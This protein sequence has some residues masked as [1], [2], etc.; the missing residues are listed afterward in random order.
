[1]PAA[2]VLLGDRAQAFSFGVPA[3]IQR[4][5]NALSRQDSSVVAHA[6]PDG[7]ARDGAPAR[8]RAPA[9]VDRH[10]PAV[11]EV[12]PEGQ[13]RAPVLRARRQGDGPGLADAVQHGLRLARRGRSRT[14][15]LLRKFDR[16][17]AGLVRDP[18]I[19]S[20]VGPGALADTSQQLNAL[21]AGPA[22]LGQ[23][24]QGRQ[25]AARHPGERARPGGRRRRPA[26]F[27]AEHRC[28]RPRGTAREPARARST[29]GS[30]RRAPAR[31][32][33]RRTSTRRS[34]LRASC[35]TARRRRSRAPRRSRATSARRP[36]PAR[37]GPRSSARWP[38]NVNTSSE[39]IKGAVGTASALNAQLAEATAAIAKLPDGPEKT[40]CRRRD[41]V[42]QLG[43]ERP[44]VLAE[45]DQQHAQR[46][47]RRGL[48]GLHAD[49]PALDRPRPALRGLERAGGGHR[50][51]ERRQRR[52]RGGHRRV[53]RQVP[54]A[55]LRRAEA[56]AGRRAARG[57][58]RPA[59]RRPLG[60]RR[61]RGTARLRARAAPSP[62]WRS[63]GRAC[64]RPRTSS[65]SRR[66]R[67][68]CSTPA[69]S[70]WR[71]SQAR[72]PRSATRRRSS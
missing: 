66:S 27:G 62:R 56:G 45:L 23:A 64:R 17:Q 47:G 46:S 26:A 33:S 60:R 35:A 70:C 59:R 18:R 52:A 71:P 63:S 14:A 31:R 43:R 3:F 65:S 67:P 13:R 4:P 41:R 15:T 36:T 2:L 24:A 61:A 29:P 72:S 7:R 37:P 25:E 9:A 40:R 48:G 53:R 21:P 51:A 49:R 20:V 1:M 8:P 28:R 11:G 42:G 12:P 34:T 10:R 5:W 19:V 54:A 32:R 39:A 30:A 55:H 44:R 57:R 58:T 38:R 6:V 69:T 68:A 16:F 22:G 50:Q